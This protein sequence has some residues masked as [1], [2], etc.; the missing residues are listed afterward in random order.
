MSPSSLLVTAAALAALLSGAVRPALAGD[1]APPAAAQ[2]TDRDADAAIAAFDAGRSG[3]TSAELRKLVATLAAVR[4]PKVTERLAAVAED[5]AAAADLRAACF[6][7]LALRGADAKSLASRVGRW[8]AKASDEEREALL[9]GDFGVPVDRRT[10]D[11]PK[12]RETDVAIAKGRAKA[13]VHAAALRCAVALGWKPKEPAEFLRPFVQ[14]AFDEL[15]IPALEVIAQWKESEALPDLLKL[16]RLYP[17]ENRWET[18][19]V[20]D[21][22]GDNASAKR[23]WNNYFGHPLKQQPRPNVVRAL[24]TTLE[25]LSGQRFTSPEALDTWMHERRTRGSA[26][27]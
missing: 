10:G 2:A 8:I 15:V 3:K 1:A 16:Y 13:M 7:Q 25:A 27:R 4:H 18:G 19:A 5:D 14:S 26:R 22:A 11:V 23:A 12:G 24:K 21:T 20:V 6:E 9:K 17:R